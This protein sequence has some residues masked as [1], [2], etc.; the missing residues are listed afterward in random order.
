M[1]AKLTCSKIAAIAKLC[2]YTNW[3]H[4]FWKFE[5]RNIHKIFRNRQ[6]QNKRNYANVTVRLRL[7]FN[8]KGGISI[9]NEYRWNVAEQKQIY[10]VLFS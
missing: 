10:L 7:I 5:R 6:D 4:H 3:W 2:L 9:E 1:L 8:R